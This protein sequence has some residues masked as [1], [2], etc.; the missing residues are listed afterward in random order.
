MEKVEKNWSELNLDNWLVSLLES[1]LGFI[2]PMPV[3]RIVI[4]LV[5]KNFDVAVESCTGSGK[6]LSFLLPIL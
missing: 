5:L 1:E 3:Q 4:P 2:N 6:T